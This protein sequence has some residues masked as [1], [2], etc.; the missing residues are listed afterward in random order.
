LID[1]G[2]RLG[3]ST[4]SVLREHPYAAL[5]GV[6]GAGLVVGGGLIG[7]T[8]RALLYATGRYMVMAAAEELLN[9]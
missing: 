7:R 4:R 6:F 2:E 8:A 3:R 5:G 9:P 1:I